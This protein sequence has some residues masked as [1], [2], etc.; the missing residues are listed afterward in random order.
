MRA[1]Q[2]GVNEVVEVTFGALLNQPSISFFSGICDE[3]EN[4]KKGDLFIAA[5]TQDAHEAIIR[6]AFGVLFSGEIAM[7]DNEVAWISVDDLN[8]A[9][10]RILRYYLMI[11]NQKLFILKE[12]EYEILSQIAIPKKNFLI[13]KGKLITLIGL[14]LKQESSYIFYFGLGF[15]HYS[16]SK[17]IQVINQEKIAD[18][19]LPFVVN[20]FSLF[21][22]RIFYKKLD[23]ALPLPKIF[24]QTLAR[25]LL[26]AEEC[27]L[28]VNLENLT[29]VSA[30]KPLYLDVRGFISKP[31]AT[32]R[33]ILS[34]EDNKLYEQYLAY[35]ALYAKWAKLT[36]FV[37]PA[38]NELFSPFA[39]VFSY[40]SKEE[41]FTLLLE[42][43]YNF[44][45]ILG[46]NTQIFEE[47]FQSNLVE[48]NLFDF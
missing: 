26:L 30:F 6:G 33:V 9:L 20:S 42:K 1:I 48:K 32:N 5:N 31:G 41:L 38:Y 19:N 13:F 23:Y 18:E 12:E 22:I 36:L 43:K 7:S 3:V 24:I 4:V 46:A 10:F 47:R 37:P 14:I 25:V 27:S 28:G 45:L 39:E 16:L 21:E 44:A 29:G 35:F 8:Q 11:Q 40:T 15:E 34:T 17:E 2:I